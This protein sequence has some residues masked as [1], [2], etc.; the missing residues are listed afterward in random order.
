MLIQVIQTRNIIKKTNK[1]ITKHSVHPIF[2]NYQKIN[3]L[4]KPCHPWDY[5][6][7]TEDL[8]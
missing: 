2:G 5:C 7:K 8:K 3:I 4:G 6:G 1:E